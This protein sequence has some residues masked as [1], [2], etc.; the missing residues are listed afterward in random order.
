MNNPGNDEAA[1]IFHVGEKTMQTRVG[2]REAIERMGRRMIR[3]YLP[4][5]H[6]QFYTQLPFLVVGSVD[7][8]GWP[9]ASLLCGQP[10]F[11][12]APTTTTL[13][14][15]A[16]PFAADPLASTL[17]PGAPLGMLGIEMPTR[18]RNRVNAHVA[19]VSD[20]GF[21][22]EVDLTFGNCP[23]Y[24][25][26]RSVNFVR[27]PADPAFQPQG[28]GMTELD[29][30]ASAMI[31]AADTFFVASYVTPENDPRVEGVDVSHR[32]GSPGF[33]R[34]EG[35]TLTIPDYPGN[36]I[37]N[38]MGNFLLNPKAG[39]IFSDFDSGDLLQLTGK[40][41]LLWEDDAEIQAFQGAQRGWRFTVEK[42][43]RLTAAL[44]FR[45]EVTS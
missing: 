9:W 31:S 37:F 28:V 27:D 4:E 14:V 33:V 15:N 12:H 36:N 34:V 11:M 23:Q 41:E 22:L 3:S 25:Q 35:N 6:R 40:V 1:P 32:G 17:E 30:A 24:I 21:A 2:K 7:D 43:V 5:Q 42:G 20:Q 18:R 13:A 39:L 10:G 29:A 45:A 38:T 44:P 19:E 26:Q 8:E 16:R